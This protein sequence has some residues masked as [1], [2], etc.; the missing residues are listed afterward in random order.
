M[1]PALDPKVQAAVH[2][3]ATWLSLLEVSAREVFQI[4]LQ[5]EL[6]NL[7]DAEEIAVSAT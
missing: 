4:M 2:P 6:E 5:I 3:D 1:N 7:P